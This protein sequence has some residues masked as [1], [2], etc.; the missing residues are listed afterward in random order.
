M[1]G[2]LK[3]NTTWIRNL[4]NPVLPTLR[5]SDYDRHCM[6]PWITKD[7][8]KKQ[9][10]L[11]YAGADSKDQRRICSAIAP[12]ENPIVWERQGPLFDIGDSGSFDG[13]W[14]VIPNL[15][16][17]EDGE[18]RI[19]YTGNSGI[20]VSLDRFP[21][22]GVALSDDGVH[23]RKYEGNPVIPVSHKEGD[24]DALGI[25][26][27]SVIHTTLPD[28][29]TQWRYYYT[30]CPTLGADIFLDQQK[31][32]CLAVSEDGLKWHKQG[33]V[34]HRHASHDYENVA[35]QQSF[36]KPFLYSFS[37][38]SCSPS[39]SPYC[40]PSS[41]PFFSHEVIHSISFSSSCG[42]IRSTFS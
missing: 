36:L 10:R 41:L 37:S 31:I 4:H 29:T 40:S 30:G 38:P 12:I 26:G 19:Y 3:Y 24:P 16:H 42:Y 11:F 32:I 8:N 35:F 2:K 34:M 27:G 17:T 21:G 25:A 23:Y 14:C 18:N 20:G 15:V 39:C 1:T 9:Y 22:L 7:D 28:G 5:D 13:D 6:N 33:A